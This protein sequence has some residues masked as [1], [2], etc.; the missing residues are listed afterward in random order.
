MKKI[1]IL[2]LFAA[3]CA[4][5]Q[6][7][8]ATQIT[9]PKITGAGTPTS[10]SISCSSANVGQPYQNTAV[11]PNTNYAC[12]DQSGTYAW[13]LVSGG[14]SGAAITAL[15]GDVTATGPGS[16]AAT[17]A[18]VNSSPGTC[19]DSTHVCQIITNGKG[20]TT[21]QTAI[22]IAT[23][24]S[25]YFTG[26]PTSAVTGTASAGQFFYATSGSASTWN[27]RLSDNGTILAYT[28]QGLS[29]TGAAGVG[30]GVS[31]GEGTATSGSS[32]SDLIYA[33]ATNHRLMQNPN[34]IGAL[35]IPGIAAAGT[36]THCLEL[37]S[38]GIDLQDSGAGCGGAS[39]PA[40]NTG[41]ILTN[42]TGSTTYAPQGQLVYQQTG[43]TI[44]SIEANTQCAALC[45]YVVTSPATITLAA[46]H[47]L[48]SSVQLHF[49]AGG[50]WTVNGSTFSLT[51][52]GNVTGTLNQH[53][54]LG[55]AAAIL[56]GQSQAIAPFE[57][58][59]AVGD[60]NGSTGT[61]NTTAMQFCLNAMQ[62][63]SGN[64]S[65]Q[66]LAYAVS[67]PLSIASTSFGEGISGTNTSQNYYGPSV[68]PASIII[69]TSATADI[70][71]VNAGWNRLT[72]FAVMRSV[73]PTGG[74]A[75]GI[76]LNAWGQGEM[77]R[78]ASEDSNY[79]FHITNGT[80][81]GGV[82]VIE[83]TIAEWGYNGV[84]PGNGTYIGFYVDSTNFAQ[85][86]SLR[87]RNV[88]VFSNLS[89]NPS[90]VTYM[91]K[92]VGTAINDLHTYGMEG[93]NLSYCAYLDYTGAHA[94]GSAA[95]IHF[96]GMICDGYTTSAIYVTGVLAAPDD[97]SV[98]FNGGWAGSISSTGT[99]V[100]VESSS[101]VTVSNMQIGGTPSLEM[102]ANNSA[103]IN[104]HHNNLF[105]LAT[106][107]GGIKL[108]GT[109]NSV[110]DGNT[111]IGITGSLIHIALTGSSNN[112]ISNNA[113]SGI[114]TVGISLDS[115]SNNNTGI[116]TNSIPSSL[117]AA[118]SDAGTN[119]LNVHPT[120]TTNG[121]IDFGA[122]YGAN[123]I[124]LYHSGS[125]IYGWGL[126]GGEMQFFT[127]DA[128]SSH[129]SFNGGSG[130]LQPSG[131]NEFMRLTPRASGGTLALTNAEV[132]GWS[133]TGSSSGTLD[134]GLSRDSAGVVDVGNGAAGNKS[135]T[136]NAATYGAGALANG[137]TATTQSPGD[138]TTKVATDAFVIANAGLVNP[139]S[140]LGDTIYGGASGTPTRLAGA[141]TNGLFLETANVTSST[142]VAPIWSN[143]TN[144]P[145]TTGSSPGLAPAASMVGNA[146]TSAT[147][148]SGTGTVTCVTAACTNV[149]GSY[150]VAGGTFATGTLLTLVWPTT[151]TAF[152]CSATV[153][154]DAT[155]ASIGYHSVATATGMNITSLTAATGL[156]VDI[157]Y[158]CSP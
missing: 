74:T 62:H 25:G 121:T 75:T 18:T 14:S 114:G 72:D 80:G 48:A 81:A 143:F 5:Q 103:N 10:L 34:A 90:A 110:V 50:K 120:S 76:L 156:T 24:S 7:N 147:G 127:Q 36:A 13:Q 68:L 138:N 113:L 146:I 20:L 73:A 56:F 31:Y 15:T 82:G 71:D 26:T 33:Y 84:T 98:E 86:P 105:A 57:W 102:L 104:F 65:L 151:T 69:S 136:I 59:G 125:S 134:T 112:V 79:A 145:L 119:H 60:W 101:G 27:P 97:G 49:L 123:A 42:T 153:V 9:W 38:N 43:D 30:G 88:G 4:A 91:L 35:I 52:P 139:M 53:F 122:N 44:A 66:A 55:S 45:T 106:G 51:I 128:T 150:T 83:N 63:S 41:Q 152:A 133:S 37:A 85:N 17:L 61:D 131:T 8:P 40:G 107:G 109:T 87:I 137:M 117:T 11:N 100:D 115:S 12:A 94:G 142:A 29:L 2:F 141:S 149:R 99:A 124:D 129:F 132:Y 140:A 39:F 111:T 108:N 28:G 22:S 70:L 157:D 1:L 47:T 16:A 32:G 89:S 96:Y 116:E 19:G 118:F 92:S 46:N 21:S 58:F 158:R 64:C 54:V 155:G 135:G 78:V 77:N 3:T 130:G 23:G 126:N 154:N 95:D 67:G 93:G 144:L 6:I 148:G